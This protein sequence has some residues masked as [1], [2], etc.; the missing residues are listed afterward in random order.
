MRRRTFPVSSSPG[1]IDALGEAVEG[2]KVGDRVF[3]LA[4]GG[5]YAEQ[6]VVHPGTVARRPEGISFTDAAAIPEAFLTAYDAI[7]TQAELAAGRTVL[8]SAVG[9]SV[10][11]AEVRRCFATPPSSIRLYQTS[12]NARMGS[13]ADVPD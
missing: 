12:R 5:T 8:I 7:V 2:F 10:G 6:L 13:L 4:G 1:K 11:T 9:S 3:G